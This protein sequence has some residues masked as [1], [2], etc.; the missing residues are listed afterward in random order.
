MSVNRRRLKF[1][2]SELLFIVLLVNGNTRKQ[3]EVSEFQIVY[4]CKIFGM[5]TATATAQ[6]EW[7]N[8]FQ[9][10]DVSVHYRHDHLF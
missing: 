6:T 9:E 2:I 7:D 10:K 5:A 4:L 1:L 8:T 3:F